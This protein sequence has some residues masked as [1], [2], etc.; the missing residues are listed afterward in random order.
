M[1]CREHLSKARLT[2]AGVI[3]GEEPG[4]GGCPGGALQ[5]C[6]TQEGILRSSLWVLQELVLQLAGADSL[7]ALL[8][9]L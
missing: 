4:L 2:G 7:W 6:V 8:G 3:Q 5:G 1:L 9:L